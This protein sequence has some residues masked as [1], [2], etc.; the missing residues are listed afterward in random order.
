MLKRVGL[1]RVELESKFGIPVHLCLNEIKQG[2][3]D[4]HRV[5]RAV[6]FFGFGLLGEEDSGHKVVYKSKDMRV[7]A[8]YQA[9]LIDLN[10]RSYVPQL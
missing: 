7:D 3:S 5:G 1:D 8:A 10:Q 6:E 2:L 9:V 4:P